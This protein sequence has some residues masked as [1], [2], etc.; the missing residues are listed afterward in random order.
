MAVVVEGVG[1]AEFDG[2]FEGHGGDGVEI[3][4]ITIFSN[5][6]MA[7][8]S[9]QCLGVDQRLLLLELRYS[10]VFD[11][12]TSSKLVRW[13]QSANSWSGVTCEDGLVVGLDLS[14][15][16]I[17]GGINGS[18]SLFRLE[19]LRSLNLAFNNFNSMA[20][21][22]GFANLSRLA[23]LNLSNAGF[24]GQIPMELSCLTKLRTLDLSLVYNIYEGLLKLEKPSLR[25]LI[26]DLG[27]LRELY[28]DWVNVSA[29]GSEWFDALS[30]SVPKLEVL[31]MSY[32]SLS[33]PIDPSLMSLSNL[34]II[35]LDGNDLSSTVP[36]FLANF[37]SLKTLSLGE[38]G[39]WGEFPHEIFQEL[40]LS[41]N[42][43][44]GEFKESF[45][46][47]SH[48]LDTLDLSNN[49]IGGE[50]PMFIWEL[51]ELSSLSLSSNNLSGSFH[52]NLIQQL[53][54]LSDLDLS[55]N[56]FSIDAT[57]TTSQASSFP[58]LESLFLASCQLTTLPQFLANQ[59]ELIVLDLSENYIQGDIPRWI[60][61][62]ESLRDLNFSSNLF[63][64][65]ETPPGNLT[66]ILIYVDLHSNRLRGNMPPLPSHASYL[67]FSSNNIYSVIPDH[68]GDNSQYLAFFSL[69]KNNF[70]ASIP[71]SICK[72][73]FLQV[74][75]LSHNHMNGT[76]PDCLMELEFLTVL[77]LRNNQLNGEILQNIPRTCNLKTLDISENLLQGQIPLSLANCTM[78]DFVNIGDN[79]IDGTFLCHLE[80]ISS[81]RV[82]VLRSNKLHGE[83]GCPYSRS[84]WKMLRIIDLSSNDFGGMLPASLMASW[85]A[86]K[87]DVDFDHLQYQTMG[88]KFPLPYY[89]VTMS[90]TLKDIQLEL[91]KILTIF[92]S[93]DFSSNRL[94]GPIPYTLGDLKALHV[95]NLSHNAI[96][97]SIPPVF[98]NLGK[99]ES[100]DL[101]GNYLNGTIPAQLANLNF[102]SLLNLSNNQLVG[103]IPTSGQFLTF[104]RSSFEGN[105]GLCGLQ[106]NKSC[107]I[108]PNGTKEVD[109]DGDND[110]SEKKWFYMGI[111]LGF[112]VGFWIFCGP[113][114]FKNATSKAFSIFPLCLCHVHGRLPA[115]R[116]AQQC[117]EQ[118]IACW[119]LPPPPPPPPTL[120]SGTCPSSSQPYLWG[121]FDFNRVRRRAL[122]LRSKP[123]LP[124]LRFCL[125]PTRSCALLLLVPLFSLVSLTSSSILSA[126]SFFFSGRVPF[127]KC[128]K[129]R[130]FFPFFNVRGGKQALISLYD[131]TDFAFLGK[132]LQELGYTV[133]STGGTASALENARLSVTKV[134]QL[135]CFPEMLDG[136][137]KT[138]HPHTHGGILARRDQ[139]HHME[140]LEKHGID[141]IENVDIG[142]PAMIRAAAKCQSGSGDKQ[143]EVFI[144]FVFSIDVI[145][146]KA[147]KNCM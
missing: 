80:S 108:T 102:L 93:I 65:F 122:L 40:Y 143:L 45:D 48:V 24:A 56:R 75:D 26:G 11:T 113:L 82:L 8:A 126:S 94:E 47:P 137:V 144:W 57:N 86:M 135:T 89:E 100:L 101:S 20:I 147:I 28:L 127:C 21:P 54:Y 88:Y 7:S 131:K 116:R 44:S 76:I 109:A 31:S 99:L 98:E 60:W 25:S 97:G 71:R 12:S 112:V 34:S 18:S 128:K 38:V 39:L 73:A 139:Q 51:R 117:A 64:D 62:L 3:S 2:A 107:S 105:L 145:A 16:S 83:I 129:I 22:S 90:V 35:Q 29:K 23:H 33:G 134:E 77:N 5:V 66:S 124:R 30:S 15:E 115:P 133:V 72:A 118:S 138:L 140:A 42:R 92:T 123:W 49:N 69:S 79:Q 120:L 95:V 1:D 111:P 136:R 61:T 103:N 141:G 146:T 19:F 17:S 106:L 50:L 46:A 63:E 43:F 81:L 67:D 53:R 32:C 78:L 96:S 37:S 84:S 55:Y 132:G 27:E 74:L 52:I 59:S 14:E 70:H 110:D 58:D 104:S 121:V 119:V 85:E 4:T 10:L 114:M 125:R 41:D 9:T 130:F 68:I 13:D 87:A 91:V 142:G 36:S 6:A